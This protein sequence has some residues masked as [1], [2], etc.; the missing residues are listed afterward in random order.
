MQSLIVLDNPKDWDL[1][2]PGVEIVPARSYLTD[3]RFSDLEKAKVYNLCKS[4]RYQSLGYY[5]SL[6]AA[7]RGHRPLPD[8]STIQDL[9]VTAIARIVA[10]D[11]DDLIQRTLAPL[12][13]ETFT[14]S[15]YFGHNMAKKYDALSQSLFNQF[16]APFLR[17]NFKYESKWEL[18]SLRAIPSSEIAEEHRPYAKEQ[19]L[20][21]FSRPS[22]PSKRRKAARYDMAILYNPDENTCPSNE[23]AIRKFV[24]AA[25]SLDFAVEII[26]KD[27]YGRLAEFDALFIRETTSVNHHTYRFA[28]R[29]AAEGLVVIDDPDS[30]LKCTNKVY[31]AELYEHH[32]VAGPR[33][34]VV[35]KENASAVGQVIGFPCVLKQ[36]DSSFSQGCVKIRDEQQFAAEAERLFR[37]SEL[38]IAQEFVP[39]GFDWRIGVLNREALYACKYHMAHDHWQ[40][41]NRTKPGEVDIGRVEAVP[42]EQAPPAVVK[43]GVKAARLIGDGLY[44]VDIKEV[45][46][47]P[48]IIEVN[49]NPSIDAGYEDQV[50][51]DELYLRVAQVF[52]ARI[53]AKRK[54]P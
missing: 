20:A 46:G 15:I 45:N 3:R 18:E 35:S 29:A 28:R 31:L 32:N 43:L 17:A 24:K 21:Y 2:V 47:K 12:K 16:P 25:E 41:Y 54:R 9:K 23:K 7:A 50:L 40:I 34:V 1:E 33:T 51:K 26:D 37:L 48:L 38:L 44:G 14:L 36:P 19:A 13:S 52:A 11:Y 5:T 42:L 39:T 27:S 22:M 4:Y 30:I 49:D 53:E 8:I 6:V 10:E